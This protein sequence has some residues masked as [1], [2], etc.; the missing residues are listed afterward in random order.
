MWK[1]ESQYKYIHSTSYA[2]CKFVIS[3]STITSIAMAE[4]GPIIK[5]Q[6][7]RDAVFTAPAEVVVLL[8]LTLSTF[9]VL[10]T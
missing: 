6:F 3:M 7:K 10:F 2:P 5:V 9:L 1:S 4:Q 8:D